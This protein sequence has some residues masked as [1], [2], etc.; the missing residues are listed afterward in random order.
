MAPFD[1]IQ[2]RE[3]PCD[4]PIGYLRIGQ[5]FGFIDV[6]LAIGNNNSNSDFHPLTATHFGMSIALC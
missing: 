4:F 3:S 6:S 1:G 5:V 2:Q